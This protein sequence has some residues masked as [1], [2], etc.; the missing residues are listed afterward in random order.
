MHSNEM[1]DIEVKVIQPLHNM[2]PNVSGV[3]SAQAGE[4]VAVFGIDAST[5]QTFTDGSVWVS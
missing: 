3:Q 5:G 1:E 4:I 2:H